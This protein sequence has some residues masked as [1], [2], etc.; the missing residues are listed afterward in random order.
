MLAW[1]RFREYQQVKLFSGL[2]LSQRGI[3]DFG[4]SNFLQFRLTVEELKL[5][6]VAMFASLFVCTNVL[7]YTLSVM[8]MLLHQENT[9]TGTTELYTRYSPYGIDLTCTNIFSL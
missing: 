1:L 3:W 5:L 2:P 8:L 4:L 9:A 6:A 7:T